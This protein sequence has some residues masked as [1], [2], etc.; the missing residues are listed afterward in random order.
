MSSRLGIILVKP[1][2]LD[3]FKK[4]YLKYKFSDNYGLASLSYFGSSKL[5]ANTVLTEFNI[6]DDDKGRR[7]SA[8][9]NGSPKLFDNNIFDSCDPSCDPYKFKVDHR[10]NLTQLKEKTISKLLNDWVEEYEPDIDKHP[11]IRHFYEQMVNT[12]IALK[13]YNN[14]SIIIGIY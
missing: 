8:I 1:T 9:I 7:L 12:L 11:V 6:R 14:Y 13:L 2:Y 5:K 10:D 3:T 4:Q